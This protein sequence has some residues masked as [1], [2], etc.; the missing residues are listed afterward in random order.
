[1]RTDAQNPSPPALAPIPFPR[2]IMKSVYH[3]SNDRTFPALAPIQGPL[4]GSHI[5]VDVLRL[6]TAVY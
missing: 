2:L 1:M 3:I 4:I 5:A 6:S